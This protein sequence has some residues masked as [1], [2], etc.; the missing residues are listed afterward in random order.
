VTGIPLFIAE[1]TGTCRLALR[2]FRFGQDGENHLH[3]ATVVIDEDAPETPRQPNGMKPAT[4][5]RVP[6]GDLRWPGECACGERFAEGD[7]WQ[8][9]EASWYEGGGHRFAWGIGSWDGPPGAMIRAPW[10]DST[11]DDNGLPAWIVFLPNGTFWCT[12]DRESRDDGQPC[13]QWQVTGVPPQI[14]VHP[15]IDDRNPARPWH[16]WIRDGMIEPA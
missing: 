9:N 3:D 2:R 15:S 1:P 6:H 7:E 14:T 10:R 11:G 13:K 16:G 8:V 12:R 4:D 5:G